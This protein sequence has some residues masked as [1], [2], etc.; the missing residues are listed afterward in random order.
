M[1]SETA[2]ASP[3][4]FNR[5]GARNHSIHQRVDMKATQVFFNGHVI[6]MDP[7]H[8][9]AKSFGLFGNRFC[10][11]GSD[12]DVAEWAGAETQVT[13]LHGRTVLPGLIESHNHASVYAM[14]LL[15]ADCS[16]PPNRSISD[17]LARIAEK[18]RSAGPGEWIQGHGYDDTLIAEKRHLTRTDLDAIAPDHPVQILHVSA[19]FSYANSRA[20]E[21]AGI[22]PNTPQPEGGHIDQ[23]ERG[24]PTGLLMEAGAM[25]LLRRCVPL[26]TTDQLKDVFLKAFDY[27]HQFGVTSIHDAG[28]GY[29]RHGS[30]VIRAY[31]E[32]ERENRLTLRV[33]LT[34]IEELF[35]QLADLGFRTGFG[36]ELL[37]VGSV[38]AF[39]DG[40]IQGLTGALSEP[41]HTRPE[42]TG[43]LLI[44]QDVLDAFVDRYHA[45]GFQIALHA[46]GDRAIES[47]LQAFEKA[48]RHHPTS[49]RR[50]MIIH[51]QTASDDHIRRMKRVGII[52]NYFVNHVYYWGDRHE[53][54]F[55]GPKRAARL[56]P[57]KSSLQ[58]DLAFCLHSDLPVTPVDPFFSI[59]TAVNR[60]TRDGKVLGPDER[61][62]VLEAIKAYTSTAAYV[63]F[64][65]HEKGSIAAGK[66]ADFV[67][68]SG[69]PLTEPAER[70]KDIHPLQTFLGGEIVYAGGA[71]QK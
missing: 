11:V 40:S 69:N 53:A 55:L 1:L 39:Q 32:L 25:D 70:I 68:L 38:K 18:A 31:Q 42:L 5:A 35:R 4:V 8:P 63:S 50:H 6:T 43:D 48:F 26:Y 41:Y 3:A 65:E 61:I 2:Q 66:L 24:I 54:I 51:C 47:V 44:S 21:L 17:V 27:F 59:H 13:D 34:I 46:N 9:E 57:L 56:D 30:R 36:S 22:G 12:S 45:D 14:N 60:T 58:N 37:K 33:H 71:A 10:V 67:V 29:F 49:D 19:H 62:P 28:I 64:G 23:D 7:S 16:T 20:L 15:K 52:P